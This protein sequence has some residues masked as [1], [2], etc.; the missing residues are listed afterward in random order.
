[1][2]GIFGGGTQKV[3]TGA[4]RAAEAQAQQAREAAAAE[5]RRWQAE[6][7]RLEK[8]KADAQA[9]AKA[10]ELAD[11]GKIEAENNKRRLAAA[12]QGNAPAVTNADLAQSKQNLPGY[13]ATVAAKESEVAK[14]GGKN[15]YNTLTSQSGYGA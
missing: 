15:G 14:L 7:A 10:Q 8:E 4:Q 5:E 11:K 13:M 6:Q 1:M 9:A 2:G 3:D 12:A